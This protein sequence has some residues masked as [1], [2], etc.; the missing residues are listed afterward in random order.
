MK[1][2]N[3]KML[4]IGEIAKLAGLKNSTIR[5]YT[6][7]GL[8][9]VTRYSP[10]GYRLFDRDKAIE[11]LTKIRDMIGRRPSLKEIKRRLAQKVG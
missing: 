1:N 3:R 8:L 10:G 5:F 7:I 2:E 9:P 4:K 6:N 11:C